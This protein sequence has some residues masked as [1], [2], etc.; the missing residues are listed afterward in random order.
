M[1]FDDFDLSLLPSKMYIVVRRFLKDPGEAIRCGI[2]YQ[3]G[4]T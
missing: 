4:S 3:I 1:T 2:K